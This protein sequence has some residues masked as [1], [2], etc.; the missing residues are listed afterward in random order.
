MGKITMAKASDLEL[1][2]LLDFVQH[3]EA[4]DKDGIGELGMGEWLANYLISHEGLPF[5]V[6]RIVL[7][8]QVM[9]DNACDPSASALEWKPSILDMMRKCESGEQ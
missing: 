5:S 7:G 8:Y 1:G 9:F 3:I 6:E 2:F 4:M